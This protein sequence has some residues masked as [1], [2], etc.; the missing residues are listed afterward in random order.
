M[1]D[2]RKELEELGFTL[3]PAQ[4]EGK[5]ISMYRPSIEINATQHNDWF[6]IHGEIRL[7]PFKIPFLEIAK[8]IKA[9]NRYFPL[10]D[11]TFFL[12]PEEWM[13]R[14]REIIS[15]GRFQKGNLQIAKSQYMLLESLGIDASPMEEADELMDGF[16]LST[17]LKATLRPYQF[18]GVQWLAKHYYNE[19]GA[20][21][22]DDMGLG[23][24]LQTI[25]ILLHAKDA[26]RIPAEEKSPT[27]GQLEL[28]SA[29][30]PDADFLRP[31]NALIILPASLIFN[32]MQEIQTFAPIL[33]MFN[34]TGAKRQKDPRL[35]SRFDVI[36]TTYQTALRDI[37][38]LQKIQFEYIVL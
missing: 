37:D 17:H 4:A 9:D 14:Y 8:Y 30:V 23:K 16:S 18:A 32:W 15:F 28:F 24:T 31:L 3:K 11:G 26:K 21:L 33:S 13:N 2:H 5:S 36:I 22:A 19:L 25:A 6:D 20:C 27:T 1:A 34:H 12:I 38:L 7:G 29:A 35:L 10:P